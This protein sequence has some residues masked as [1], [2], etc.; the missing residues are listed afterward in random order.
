MEAI[1]SAVTVRERIL[2]VAARLFVSEGYHGISMREI[3]QAAGVS[4][5]GLYYHFQDKEALFLGVL[6]AN[7][8][9]V[10]HII[11]MSREQAGST[12]ERIT[13]F[14]QGIFALPPEQRAIIRLA[15]QEISHLQ[16]ETQRAFARL[17]QRK[18]VDQIEVV[19]EEGVEAGELRPVNPRVATWALLGMLYPLLYPVHERYISSDPTVL[20]QMLDIFFSGILAEGTLDMD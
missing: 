12:R 1:N 6:T 16:P 10:E 5:A 4:K 15:T 18:F 20:E 14:V 8:E 13:R 3:A 2:N 7:L 9:R 17:Y 11:E 19:F